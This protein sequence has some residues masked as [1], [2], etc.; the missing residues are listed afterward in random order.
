M[1]FLVVQYQRIGKREG[2]KKVFCI[3]L[4]SGVFSH[5]IGRKLMPK[6]AIFMYEVCDIVFGET[7]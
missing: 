6:S 3:V 4:P 1:F 7:R 5:Y 2:V